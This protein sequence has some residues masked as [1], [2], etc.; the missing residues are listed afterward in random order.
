MKKWVWIIGIGIVILLAVKVIFAKF[1]LLAVGGV[2]G[3]ILGW[4]SHSVFGRLAGSDN[5]SGGISA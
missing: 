2:G 5:G 1:V 4:I 3:F